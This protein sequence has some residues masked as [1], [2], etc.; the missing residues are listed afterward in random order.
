MKTT[1]IKTI[2]IFSLMLLAL[3]CKKEETTPAPTTPTPTPSVSSP[4]KMTVGGTVYNYTSSQ[5]YGFFDTN[6][7]DVNVKTTPGLDPIGA[8]GFAFTDFS[9]NATAGSSETMEQFSGP[10]LFFAD[11]SGGIYSSISGTVSYTAHNKSARTIAGTF[12]CVL[13]NSFTSVTKNTSGSFNFAY[14]TNLP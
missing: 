8:G 14:P 2:A 6:N 7:D 4:F 13:K 12:T 3:S 1:T 11:N 5:L 10:N 9:E